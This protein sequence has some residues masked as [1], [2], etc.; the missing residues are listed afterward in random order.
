VRL[1]VVTPEQAREHYRRQGGFAAANA[2][3]L[4]GFT[5]YQGKAREPT[6]VS[7]PTMRTA[8]ERPT[9]QLVTGRPARTF[10]QWARD[11]A[12]NLR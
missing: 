9:A 6:S 2:D 5:D 4:L 12:E 7:Y 3:F 11:H 8:G 1:E 10:A